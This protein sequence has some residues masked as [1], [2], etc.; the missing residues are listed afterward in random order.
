MINGIHISSSQLQIP[1]GS[2]SLLKSGLLKK[3]Q[4]ISAKVLQ[5]LPEGKAQLLVDGRTVTAKTGL[6]LTPGENI[7]LKV[8]HSK[9]EL[10]LKL[11]GPFKKVKPDQVGVL[12]RF[13]SNGKIGPRLPADKTSLAQ[14][15]LKELSIKSGKADPLFLPRLIEKGGLQ[16]EN[17]IADLAGKFTHNI[18]VKTALDQ[19]LNQDLKG[20]LLKQLQ[21]V[22]GEQETGRALGSLLEHLESFQQVN[23]QSS[24]SNRYL[25]PFPIFSDNTFRFG[26]LLLDTGKGD[27]D[28]DKIDK[29]SVINISFLLDM[30]NLGALRADFSILKKAIHGR[31]L[32][33]DDEI[34]AYV[35]AMIPQLKKRLSE[36]EYDVG[37]IECT[38]AEPEQLEPKT[39]VDGFLK[40][41]ENKIV[42]IIV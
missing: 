18:Q 41:Q 27:A 17:K 31:F 38:A 19:L 28:M 26:Q 33:K 2:A 24:E 4:V 30:T 42:S 37:N 21:I 3:N 36:L 22:A 23:Y 35:S 6:L 8:I 7:E 14:P 13:L 10:V 29:D 25:L 5:L 39:L 1:K 40:E 34:C 32:L 11:V 20:V 12:A 9:D 15:L 16:F